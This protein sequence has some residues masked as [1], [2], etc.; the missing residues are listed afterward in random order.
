VDHHPQDRGPRRL[1]ELELLALE[2]YFELEVER[3]VVA[4]VVD[5]VVAVDLFESTF[6]LDLASLCPRTWLVVEEASP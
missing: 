4:L 1:D 5:W 2:V 6:W 3:P